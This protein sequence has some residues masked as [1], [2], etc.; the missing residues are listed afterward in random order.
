MKKYFLLFL[1]QASWVVSTPKNNLV[2]IQKINPTFC[3]ELP[4]ATQDNFTHEVIYDC[5]KCYL[6]H[7]VALRLDAV[8]KDFEKM[9]SKEHPK[10]LG[11]K[12]WDGYRPLS[13]QKK[14]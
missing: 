9:V 11:L 8:Q 4:Y 7:T 1:I 6:L 14:M 12:I 5:C 3:I 10:G 13:A 2:N